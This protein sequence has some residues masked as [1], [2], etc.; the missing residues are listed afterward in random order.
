[1]LFWP[2]VSTALYQWRV[3]HP[4]DDSTLDALWR[5]F[6]SMLVVWIMVAGVFLRSIN[7]DYLDTFTSSKTAKKWAEEAFLENKDPEMKLLILNKNRRLWKHLRVKVRGFLAKE[8]RY[9]ELDQPD[10]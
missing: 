1:M 4:E 2:F 8:W 7:P 5:L 10:W 6:T 3:E 9:W